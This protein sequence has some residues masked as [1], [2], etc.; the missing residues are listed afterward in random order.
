ME[1]EGRRKGWKRIVRSDVVVI[2]DKEWELKTTR[3]EREVNGMTTETGSDLQTS[4][5]QRFRPSVS[6]YDLHQRKA[7]NCE[8]KD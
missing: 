6:K 1:G 5:K 3:N 7:Q 4:R 8:L 2:I